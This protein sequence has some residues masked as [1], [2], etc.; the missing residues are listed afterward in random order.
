MLIYKFTFLCIC[1]NF[2]ALQKSENIL[3]RTR[4]H[5]DESHAPEG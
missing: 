1:T 2:I 4:R 5:A 3:K